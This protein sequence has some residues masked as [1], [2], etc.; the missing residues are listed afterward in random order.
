M[1]RPRSRGAM[2]AL[3]EIAH[4]VVALDF[5]STLATHD[6][7]PWDMASPFGPAERVAAIDAW[8]RAMRA[9]DVTLALVSRNV[10]G[11]LAQCLAVAGWSELFGKHV[12]GREDV[13]SYSAWHGRKSVLIRRVLIEQHTMRAEDVLFVDDSME[14]C[15]EVEK[16]IPGAAI[17]HVTGK[18]GLELADLDK[19]SSWVKGRLDR[20]HAERAKSHDAMLLDELELSGGSHSGTSSPAPVPVR[21]IFTARVSALEPS[22]TRSQNAT[23]GRWL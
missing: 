1:F 10:R 17:L 22:P 5:D 7:M 2:S 21:R 8:L 16:H 9:G 4:L 12:Y 14:N 3:P 13:E 11:V 23:L 15:R 19:V 20:P 6:V 18:Y